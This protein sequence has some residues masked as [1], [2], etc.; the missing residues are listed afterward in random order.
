L[1][2][3]TTSSASEPIS[4]S[5]LFIL[6]SPTNLDSFESLGDDLRKTI[7][8]LSLAM[9]LIKKRTKN[10]INIGDNVSGVLGNFFSVANSLIIFSCNA[11]T[12]VPTTDRRL[13]QRWLNTCVM[14]RANAAFTKD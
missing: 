9:Q 4:E 5:N 2:A 10:A 6:A 14:E 3:R 13:A 8:A 1:K 7:R 12:T 11:S